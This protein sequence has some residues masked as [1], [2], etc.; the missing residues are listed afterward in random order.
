MGAERS[1]LEREAP[2]GAARSG[3][4]RGSPRGR[5]GEGRGPRGAEAALAVMAMAAGRTRGVSAGMAGGEGEGAAA[6]IGGCWRGKGREP[7]YWERG[8]MGMG[9]AGV[10]RPFLSPWLRGPRL[11]QGARGEEAPAALGPRRQRP[12]PPQPRAPPAFILISS[13]HFRFFFHD[14]ISYRVVR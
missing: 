14:L 1:G 7:I 11:S 5:G 13:G 3:R 2:E 6:G 8:G 12:A 9:W 10:F 4:A